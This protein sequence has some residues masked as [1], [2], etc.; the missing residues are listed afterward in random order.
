MKTMKTG[1][2]GTAES[3]LDFVALLFG[4]NE[5]L[6][7]FFVGQGESMA[8]AELSRALSEI[9]RRCGSQREATT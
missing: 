5:Q 9:E 7:R 1:E 8:A 2:E 4:V 3:E 6:R